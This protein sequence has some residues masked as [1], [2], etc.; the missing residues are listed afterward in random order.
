[1]QGWHFCSVYL[2]LAYLFRVIWRDYD[3]LMTEPA[4]RSAQH[5]G[6][7]IGGALGACAL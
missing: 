2:L 1:M 7:A 4:K 5:T 6:V 3:I